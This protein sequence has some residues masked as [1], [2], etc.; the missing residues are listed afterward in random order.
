VISPLELAV[1]R[2]L[3][4]A[5]ID[6]DYI[7]VALVRQQKV[8]DGAGGHT[9]AQAPVP[10]QRFRLVP[11]QD[12]AKEMQTADGQM[13]RPAYVLLGMYDCDMQRNDRFTW[14]G[15]NLKIV[16]VEDKQYEVKGEV[17]YDN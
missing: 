6:A 4:K 12:T 2:K 10:A 11:R 15:H 8:D 1:Q 3:T 9:Y 16:H 5:F 14:N 17:I 13:V 7:P